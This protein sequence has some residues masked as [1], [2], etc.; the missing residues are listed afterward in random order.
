MAMAIL[1]RL[2]RPRQ[3][4]QAKAAAGQAFDVL[5]RTLASSNFVKPGG[6]AFERSCKHQSV[7]LGGLTTPPLLLRTVRPLVSIAIVNR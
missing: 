3:A 6:C 4:S 5:V 2:R 1:Q 7:G